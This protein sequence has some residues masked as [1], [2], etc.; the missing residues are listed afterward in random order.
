MKKKRFLA[1]LDQLYKMLDFIQ[2]CGENYAI[3][4]TALDQII[5]ASEEV[6]VNVIQYGYPQ[7]E[8]GDIEITCEKLASKSGIKITIIDQG[9]SFDPTKSN[10]NI[11]PNEGSVGGYG[12]YLLKQLVDQVEYE[13]VNNQN[14][15]I[16]T[17]CI[18]E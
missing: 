1:A 12:I 3:P 10:F 5:L 17:K 18:H 15:L 11:P 13:R 4:K 8:K 7:P 2:D 14:I 9:I 16:L 6:L